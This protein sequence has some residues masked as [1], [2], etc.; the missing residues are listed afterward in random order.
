MWI[1]FGQRPLKVDELQHAL[2]IKPGDT[3]FDTEGITSEKSLVECCMGLV[4]VETETSTIRLI[5]L[6]LQEYFDK[7]WKNSDLFPSGHSTI[8]ATCLTYLQID[9]NLPPILGKK[10]FKQLK[11]PEL[12]QY[13]VE[14]VGP[15]LQ[16]SNDR[17][18]AEQCVAI[19]GQENKFQILQFGMRYSQHTS[20]H[21]AAYFG[22][23]SVA[24]LLIGTDNHLD[25]NA[26]EQGQQTPMLH[27]TGRGNEQQAK[28]KSK[29][30]AV[31]VNSR[32]AHGYTPLSFAAEM[33]H[34]EMVR[35]L[36]DV[37]G[38]DANSKTKNGSTPLSYAA[39]N[40]HTAIAQLLL[41]TPGVDVSASDKDGDTPLSLAAWKGH[42]EVIRLLLGA[43]GV[44]VDT[45]DKNGDTPL[46]IAARSG[47]EA[48]V[49][50]LLS[51][52]EIDVNHKN[53]RG[54]TP[55]SLATTRRH[56]DVI[57]LLHATPGIEL[58]G[59]S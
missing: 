46:S 20:L 55:L 58:T 49:R 36:L 25:L 9:H 7:H 44:V 59:E 1:Y 17:A 33:G 27:A 53:H 19:L 22:C 5:H 18:L 11:A 37:P 56:E 48:V 21:W 8:A 12:L 34:E 43:L 16:M 24:A 2:A 38:V 39:R 41:G 50:L 54:E 14:N 28:A 13:A 57:R 29:R 6:T 32:S 23:T 31:N 4:M 35:L 3:T 40:G 45:S 42:A 30:S 52:P 47:H 51:T 15:H 26:E 10:H